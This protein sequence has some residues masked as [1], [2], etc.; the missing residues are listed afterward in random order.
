M[1][2][3]KGRLLI[4]LIMFSL[5]SGAWADEAEDKMLAAERF[6]QSI[7]ADAM[8]DRLL[9][10]IMKQAA[11]SRFSGQSERGGEAAQVIVEELEVS[12]LKFRPDIVVLI[13]AFFEK[14]FTT[15][16][17][18]Q[19]AMFFSAKDP[20]EE[21]ESAFIQSPVWQKFQSVKLNMK[22]H[23]GEDMRALAKRIYQ[24]AKP[25]IQKRLRGEQA[26]TPD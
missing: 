26:N 6:M 18:S 19:M 21:D 9:P 1:S 20:T 5:P 11:Q 24:D 15:E 12:A 23:I 14:A 3:I 7:N 22:Q 25:R 8:V 13:R 10:G 2:Y 17:L 4:F 16:E